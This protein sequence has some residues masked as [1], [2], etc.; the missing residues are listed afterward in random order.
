MKL[1]SEFK[2]WQDL[3]MNVHANGLGG[4]VD[5]LGNLEDRVREG[6]RTLLLALLHNVRNRDIIGAEVALIVLLRKEVVHHVGRAALSSGGSR[7]NTCR[8]SRV[9]NEV[10][11]S[12]L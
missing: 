4:A 3:V 7:R 12:V 10:N 2:S 6:H 9:Y 1:E 8:R 5:V 11:Y